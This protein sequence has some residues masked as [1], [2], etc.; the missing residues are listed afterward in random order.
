M[1]DLRRGVDKVRASRDGHEYHEIWTARRAT[2]LLWPDCDL[3]AIAVEGL[4]PEDQ[5]DAL[6]ETVEIADITLYYG[7]RP[8][9]E[10]AFRTHISQF[11]YSIASAETPFRASDAKKTI[12]KFA[13]AYRDHQDRYGAQAVQEKL[14]FELITNRPIFEP[15]LEAIKAISQGLPTKG[16]LEEQAAQIRDAAHFDETVLAAFASKL[17][18]V[19]RSGSLS[20]NKR[21]LSGLI[22]DWSAT[23]DA[24]ADK[25][26]GH[27]KQLVRDKAGDAGTGQ[28]LITRTDILAALDVGDPDDLLPCRNAL[29]DVGERVGREQLAEAVN[30]IRNGNKPLLIHAP[31]GVGKT[32]FMD[33]LAS[34]EKESDEVVFF[35]CFGGGAYRSPEDA[36]HLAKN[37]LMHIANTLAFR[38]LCDPILPS[39]SDDQQL[40]R[41]FRRRLEQSLRTLNAAAAG[42]GIAIFLDAVDNAELIARRRG[43]KAFPVLLLESLHCHPIPGVKLILSCRSE[44]KPSSQ[45]GCREFELRSFDINET[46]E[47]LRSRLNNVSQAAINVAQARSGGNPRVLDYLVASGHG[48]FD[49]S[50]IDQPLELDDL[51]QQRISQALETAIGSGYDQSEIDAFLAGLAVLPPPVPLA[52]YASAHGWH[53]SAIESFA[54]DLCP[55][56][57][58]TSQGLIFRDEPTET[59]ISNRYGSSR[60]ALARVAENLSAHQDTSV[61]A[62]RALP[63][64]LHNLDDGGKLFELAFDDRIPAKIT[65]TVGKRNIRYARIKAAVLHSA[66]KRDYNRL[67]QLLLELSTL[68]VVDQRGTEYILDFPDLAVSADDLD[69]IRRLFE[70]RT[71]WPGRRHARLGIAYL[72]SGQSEEAHRHIIKADEWINHYYRS[73]RKD[74]LHRDGPDR[75]D[76][77]AVPLFLIYTDSPKQAVRYL[78]RW[79]EFF[80]FEVCEYL[81]HYM[82]TALVLRVVPTSKCDEFVKAARGLGSLA[83]ALSFGN[84]LKRTSRHLVGK[85]SRECRR[86]NGTPLRESYQREGRFE[87]GDGFRK[88]AAL[89]LSLGLAEDAVAI[90]RRAPHE[91][92]LLSAVSDRYF[93]GDIFGFVFEMAL[94]AA[95][96][97]KQL[98]ERALLPKELVPLASGI[99]KTLSG[100]NFCREL[101]AEISERLSKKHGEEQATRGPGALSHE[102]KHEAERFLNDR[103]L[104]L[105]ALTRALSKFVAASPRNLDSAFVGLVRVWEDARKEKDPYKSEKCDRL[106][107]KLGFDATLFSLWTRSE[108][109][110]SSVEVFLAALHGQEIAAYD[111]VQAVRILAQRPSTR[112][113]A[114][115]EAI[116]A[117]ALIDSEDD[118]TRRASLFGELARA[119]LP[120]SIEE[121]SVYFRHGLERMDAI[122]SGDYA[123][124]NELLLFAAGAKGNELEE[125]DFHTLANIS[126]LNLGYEPEKFFWGAFARALSRCAGPRGLAKLSRWD[127]RSR[128]G[129]DHTLLPYLTALVEHDKIDP[130]TALALNRLANP[131][132]YHENGTK[133]FAQAVHAK[134]KNTKPDV[135]S[136]LIGQFEDDNPDL[137][138]PSTVE[139]LSTIAKETFGPFS[140]QRVYLTDAYN[141]YKGAVDTLNEHN[142]YMGEVDEGSSERGAERDRQDQESMLEIIGEADPKDQHSFADVIA[143]LNDLNGARRIKDGF[144]SLL[145]EKVSY[146]ERGQY[147]RNICSSECLNLYWKLEE[148]KACKAAWGGSS[149]SLVDV[150]NAEA[151]SLISYHLDDLVEHG[152]LSGYHI[153]EISDL[154]GMGIAELVCHV[155]AKLVRADSSVSGAIWL[156]TASLICAEA[157]EGVGQKA[158]TRLLNSETAKLANNVV[159]GAWVDRLYP[160]N[161]LRSIASGL[162]WRVLG[163]PYAADRWRAGHS[164]R[165]FAKFGRWDMIDALMGKLFEEDAG[166]F[167]AKELRFYSRHARLWLVIALARMALDYP[168]EI[169]TYKDALLAIVTDREDPHV[170]MRHFAARTL[171]A[172]VDAGCL[173]LSA[174]VNRQ[175]RSADISP[176]PR[177]RKKLRNNGGFYQGRPKTLREPEFEF[178]LDYEFHKQ[179]VDYL[180]RVFGKACWEVEDMISGIVHRLDPHATAMYEPDGRRAPSRYSHYARGTHYHTYG[181]HLGWHA[182]F[183]AAGKLLRDCPVTEDSWSDDPWREWLGDYLL[184]RDDGFWLS[185][186]MDRKPLDS[187]QIL[188]EKSKDSLAITGD[189]DKLLEL[190]GIRSDVIDKLVVHASWYSTDHIRVRISSALVAPSDALRLG[191]QLAGEEPMTVWVPT[192]SC[193]GENL[194]DH[195]KVEDGYLPWIVSPSGEARLDGDDPLGTRCANLR[196]WIAGNYAL[197]LSLATND[198]FRREWQ[199]RDGAAVLHA[200]AWGRED[201]DSD[202][203][204]HSGLRLRCASSALKSILET[205]DNDLLV[206]IILERREK[207]YKDETRYSHTSAVVRITKL[208]NVEYIAGC[209]NRPYTFRY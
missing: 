124:T 180:G 47:F 108:L 192:F 39:T 178:Q 150:Y 204:P 173:K 2:Q 98:D 86:T 193:E 134:A 190:V 30:L 206:S 72:L 60:D 57:E 48:I 163:S 4:S 109:K 175:V 35:D 136:E 161:D 207:S 34:I 114:G 17:G 120:T 79:K 158:L 13:S 132:E 68:A 149:A 143:G 99:R 107:C 88:A 185:D 32:V 103:L 102:Q 168:E 83:A 92:F 80:S 198:P 121:A 126:E 19:G 101:K 56:L 123:F 62:A 46:S 152:Y 154:T 196:P 172:C 104:P 90:A 148:L 112:H 76:I 25:R 77:A 61:Y 5:N 94:L 139:A 65:S 151:I 53:I 128:I 49:E 96:R 144:F 45:A 66:I 122:G 81:F 41:T 165:C 156:G 157:D 87:L 16:E 63:A 195:S 37:G 201:K 140:D 127:D 22:V 174:S 52:E 115:R 138:T 155:V 27:L 205:H 69:A 42:R 11:K 186:G 133:Q 189:R 141:R 147:I 209:V 26:L 24:L 91:R 54:A 160:Q 159:D 187:I 145:R 93:L 116:K 23:S 125:R 130:E 18:V 33:S 110:P 51:I 162:V 169:S 8:T 43:E 84:V 67:V 95:V 59:L 135:I 75:R 71:G 170:L 58:R 20:A 200:E 197:P 31:G 203:G 1:K 181:Q 113:L 6:T 10:G 7:D 15:L 179:D 78:Q 82:H 55:L 176:Y 44:R 131:V 118:V 70:A 105:L 202:R 137:R 28:N 153:K 166:P 184:T 74:Q 3:C 164:I 191:Q 40:L 85:L 64:L 29:V 208:L 12:E 171:V 177:L 129:L 36:R 167:Q 182:L 100:Q 106:F 111:V 21:E 142:N 89:A 183:L 188:L 50:E 146:G 73:E 97:H 117:R 199:G 119:M 14:H 194:G 38:G 9:F